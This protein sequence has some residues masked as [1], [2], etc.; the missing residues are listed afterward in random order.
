MIQPKQILLIIG[1]VLGVGGLIWPSN[2]LTSCG[3]VFIGVAGL[4]PTSA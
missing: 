1:I 2:V 4:I 3:V